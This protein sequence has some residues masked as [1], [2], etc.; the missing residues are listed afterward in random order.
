MIVAS[1]RQ[2]KDK[3]AGPV[4]PARER[5]LDSLIRV[6]L[7]QKLQTERGGDPFQPVEKLVDLGFDHETG[8]AGLFDGVANRVK[9]HCPYSHAPETGE[10][11]GEKPTGLDRSHIQINL[12]GP[13]PGSGGCL[14]AFDFSGLRDA[15]LWEGMV[16]FP[17]EDPLHLLPRRHTSLPYL[18]QGDKQVGVRRSSAAGHEVLKVPRLARDVIDHEVDDDIV[19]FPK[20]SNVIPSPEVGIDLFIGCR[21]KSPIRGRGK[22]REDVDSAHGGL[23]KPPIHDSLKGGE[24]TT[25]GVGVGDELHLIPDG[26][27]LRPS[28]VEPRTVTSS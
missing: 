16:R 26:E 5:L 14:D 7:G 6:D 24:S 28:H 4:A 20:T 10:R 8:R 22:G 25:Q 12:L 17:Q 15:H 19:P 27:L 3:I 1:T 13:I 21:R 18:V 11:I 2:R 9:P 23:R